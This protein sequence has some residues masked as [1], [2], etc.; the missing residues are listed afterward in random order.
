MK[1]HR[2]IDT[3]VHLLHAD[4]F[5]YAWCEG[6][7][8]LA[9]DHTLADYRRAAAAGPASLRIEA[10]CFMEGDVPAAEL[11]AETAY[12]AELAARDAAIP[13]LA[14]LVAGVRPEAPD[15]PAQLD[16]LRSNPRVRAVRRVL[17]T[18][19]DAML[20]APMLAANLRRLAVTG[21]PFELCLRPRQLALVTALVSACPETDFIV[22]HAAAPDVAGGE[23][24]RWRAG[25]RELAARPNVVLKFSGLGS[26]ADGAR[27]LTPQ[28]RPVFAHSLECFGPGRMLWGSDWPVTADL[29]TWLDTT[30]TLFGELAEAERDAIAAGNAGRIYGVRI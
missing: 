18:Q 13:Q 7:P 28:V 16:A 10:L 21:L 22:D 20:A 11:A 25:L 19:P 4:R 30:A 26:L 6:V 24:A 12:F 29:A 2:L 15:F 8:A 14:A 17:H 9:G 3:H 5:T 23:F 1:P 27:P